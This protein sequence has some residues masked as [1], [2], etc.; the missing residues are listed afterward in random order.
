[1]AAGARSAHASLTQRVPKGV[2]EIEIRGLQTSRHPVSQRTRAPNSR[3][4]A[5]PNI[6]GPGSGRRETPGGAHLEAFPQ[7]VGCRNG[8]PHPRCASRAKT[9][10]VRAP[11][12]GANAPA[13]RFAARNRLAN[14]PEEPSRRFAPPGPGSGRRETPSEAIRLLFVRAVVT[15]G[16]GG[17]AFA[18]KNV[19]RS[20]YA[21]I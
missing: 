9:R 21:A 2:P 20:A 5:G 7:P 3:R 12:R 1:M 16:A 15:R 19:P 4:A 13:V 17:A 6:F 14:A 8:P 11:K 18:S 10:C